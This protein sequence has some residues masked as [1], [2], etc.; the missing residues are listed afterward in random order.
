MGLSSLDLDWST[1]T[2]ILEK[3]IGF[4]ISIV[5]VTEREIDGT[6]FQDVAKKI[7]RLPYRV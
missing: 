4:R 7:D 6:F 5:K 3:K 1:K 2:S